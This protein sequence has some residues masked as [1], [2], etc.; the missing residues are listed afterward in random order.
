LKLKR[1]ANDDRSSTHERRGPELP[2]L[3]GRGRQREPIVGNGDALFAPGVTR[4]RIETFTA[5][6]NP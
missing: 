5:R 2:A 3:H 1:M 6:L 4:Q